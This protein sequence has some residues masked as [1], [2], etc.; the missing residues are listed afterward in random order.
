MNNLTRFFE[1]TQVNDELIPAIVRDAL[2]RQQNRNISC[3][4]NSV[5]P[6]KQALYI[7]AFIGTDDA[8]LAHH[9][10]MAVSGS[11]YLTEI[12]VAEAVVHVLETSSAIFGPPY[13][14]YLDNIARKH[15]EMA[16]KCELARIIMKKRLNM[17]NTEK[18]KLDS[19]V[20]RI[21]HISD[22]HMGSHHAY[23]LDKFDKLTH[24]GAATSFARDISKLSVDFVINS[25]DIASDSAQDF[26]IYEGFNSALTSF[27]SEDRLML[28]PG[29][30]DN[31]WDGPSTDL[32]QSFK[33]DISDKLNILTPF[34]S[35]ISPE[36]VIEYEGCPASLQ[37]F[38][39]EG[40]LCLLLTSCY[41]TGLIAKDMKCF[42]PSDD[43]EAELANR[44]RFEH[45]H[46]NPQYLQKAYMMVD[47]FKESVG[48][49]VYAGLTKIAVTH[50]HF[51]A[52]L[53][54][55][56]TCINGPSLLQEL[57]RLDF[58]IVLHGHVHKEVIT[59]NSKESPLIVGAPTL[60]AKD[61]ER[62]NGFLILVV[63]TKNKVV[64]RIE[65]YRYQE[66]TL[67]DEPNVKSYSE[68]YYK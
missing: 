30:H 16:T 17:R 68:L 65:S 1:L 50:H 28:V 31:V 7:R 46:F 64:E 44:L 49:D 55:E 10:E 61:R 12:P 22:V 45:G 6:K 2:S 8:Q 27:F 37:Y 35:N 39:D 57:N 43:P 11:A 66:G 38:E 52:V 63:D 34:N 42:L 5:S 14:E 48:Q 53:N 47:A 21:C 15:S 23:P 58:D 25:G 13:E 51:K 4:L 41:Y 62:G 32:L 59:P 26:A 54:D 18:G 33:N 24:P 36:N 20:V 67:V 60:S 56:T 29:N 3:D 9:F 40:I 19:S